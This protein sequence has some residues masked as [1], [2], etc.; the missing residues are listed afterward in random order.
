M[1]TSNLALRLDEFEAE[2]PPR[3]ASRP[4]L[5][6]QMAIVESQPVERR[7]PRRLSLTTRRIQLRDPG[8]RQFRVF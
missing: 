4:S 5:A 6:T 2:N 7:A 8:L 1:N 3:A